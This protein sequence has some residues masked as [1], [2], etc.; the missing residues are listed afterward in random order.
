LQVF[1]DLLS[2]Q[3]AHYRKD[4]SAVRELLGIGEMKPATG[5]D[6]VRIAAWT[7]VAGVILNLDETI[8]KQ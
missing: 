1:R 4:R 5:L 6:P 8:T 7:A 2:Q 3:L